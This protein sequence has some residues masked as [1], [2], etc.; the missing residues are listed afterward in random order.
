MVLGFADHGNA[1]QSLGVIA[2]RRVQLQLHGVAAG[3]QRAHL[4]AAARA[5]P[6]GAQDAAGQPGAE[7]QVQGQLAGSWATP[8]K[9]VLA[10]RW[11]AVYPPH[12]CFSSHSSRTKVE[13]L[14]L[15]LEKL[16]LAEGGVLFHF[17]SSFSNE[18]L[19]A[20]WGPVAACFLLVKARLGK[21]VM[22]GLTAT[23]DGQAWPHQG[24]DHFQ[25]P[26]IKAGREV[27]QVLPEAVSPLGLT[28]I[29]SQ[30]QI[31]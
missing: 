25:R 24:Q 12:S 8:G 17:F 23:D 3:V 5:A 26:G 10:L 13:L 15:C 27:F 31:P 21:S 7:L 6:A 28:T 29:E 1:R 20:P 11:G 9:E 4:S 16:L 19:S 2:A 18:I 30:N 22:K 14:Q